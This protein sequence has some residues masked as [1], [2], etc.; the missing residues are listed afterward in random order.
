MSKTL[1]I[2]L[3]LGVVAVLAIVG[4][5][6]LLRGNDA[7][8][9]VDLDTATA[10]VTTAPGNRAATDAATGATTDPGD[11]SGTWVVD[12][13]TGT[14]DYESAT[15]SFV[16]FR[17]D[18][19][20]A[21]IG[22]TTAVGRTG[23]VTGTVELSGATVTSAQAEAKLTTITTNDDRRNAAVQRALGTDQFPT[24]TFRLTEPIQLG[25]VLAGGAPGDVSTTAN[26]ELT[27]KGVTRPVVWNLQARLVDTTI[28]VVGSTEISLADFGVEVP[29]VPIVVSA[30][31]TATIELQLLLVRR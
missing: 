23:D 2:V 11:L 26:G 21:T 15:G 29:R 12:T 31:D 10:G 17:V 8:S 6:V 5:V 28:V 3:A 19:E 20:L 7:P 24:A 1:K 30:D 13:E 9:E 14:F 25:D 27:V 22:K 4:A 18:E 16:G